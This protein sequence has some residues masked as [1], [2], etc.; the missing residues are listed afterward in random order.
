MRSERVRYDWVIELNWT[1]CLVTQLCL[2]L[3]DPLDC[4]LAGFP[5]HHQLLEL[6]Q[7]HVH[8][9]G[10]AIQWSLFLLSTSPPA[11]NLSQ[12]QGLFQWVCHSFPSKEQVSFNLMAFICDWNENWSFLV[13]WPLLSFPNFLTYWGSTITA[14]H[15]RVW[16]SSAGIPSPP[17]VSQFL[18]RLIRSPGVQGGGR[19]LRLSKWRQGSGIL[20]EEE[21][22]NIFFSLSFP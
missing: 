8:R 12:H 19:G 5:V 10:D 13:L 14:S 9:V 15:F 17:L 4:R 21:R 7:T 6:A 3:C 1:V 18:G 2:T 16:N 20:K 22:T 11:F